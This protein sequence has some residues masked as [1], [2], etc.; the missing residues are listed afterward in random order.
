[1]NPYFKND[2]NYIIRQVLFMYLIDVVTFKKL[3]VMVPTL[4][5]F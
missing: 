3:Q 4:L 2:G 5:T 1:M